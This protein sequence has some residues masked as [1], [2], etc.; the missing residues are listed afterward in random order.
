MSGRRRS[1]VFAR[2]LSRLY[3]ARLRREYEDEIESLLES[4]LERA[5]GKPWAVARIQLAAVRDLVATWVAERRA[6]REAKNGSPRKEGTMSALI[7]DVRYA[8]RRLVRTPVF[9]FGALAIMTIAIGANTAVFAAVNRMLFS[10][11]P[12]V[13]PDRV[14]NIYQDSDDGEPSSNSYPAYLDM[15][16]RSDVFASVAATSPDNAAL[17]TDG[18]R[19]AVAI[20][21]TTSSFLSVIR[22]RPLRGRWF[23]A[24][25]DQVGAGNFAVVSN[26]T[27][28]TRYGAD[29]SLIGSTIRLNGQPV[30]VIGVGPE[31]FNGFGR[32]VVTDFWL[33]ISSVGV[34]GAYRVSNLDRRQDHWYQVLA[35]LAPGVSDARAQQAMNALAASLA[36]DFPELNEGRDITVF[37]AGEVRVHPS[38]D[39]NL[40]SLGG[41]LMA[42]VVLV[43][44]LASSNLGSLLLVRGV[45]RGPEIAVRRALGAGGRRVAGLFLAEAFL[46]TFGG[47]VLGLLFA[48]WT[49]GLLATA[50]LP[51]GPLSGELDL[52]LDMPVLLFSL[53]LV[54][55]TGVFF[56]WA[57]ALQSLRTD[58]AGTLREDRRTPGGRR[59]SLLRNAMVSVQVAVSLILVALA[60]MMVRSLAASQRV[61]V[62]VDVERLAFLKTTLSQGGVPADAY[63]PVLSEIEDQFATVPGVADVAFATR[64]PVQGGGTT[65]TVVE[66]YEP[67][68]GTGSVELPWILVSPDYLATAGVR[69]LHGRGYT[70]ADQV[71][72]ERVVI[73]NETAAR[74]FWGTP[75]AVG[76]RIRP[77]SA[78]DAW[79]NVIGVVEDTKVESLN[80]PPTPLLYYVLGES[81]LNSPY[82]MVRTAGDP[83]SVLPGLR[84]ALRAVN[85]QL[86]VDGLGT[87][88]THLGS[89]LASTRASAGMLGLFS[90]LALLLASVGIYTIVSF[91]VAGRMPEIGIRVALGAARARVIRLVVGEV[92]LTVGLGLLLGTG[93]VVAVGARVGS[94]FLGMELLHAGTLATALAILVATV[95]IASY[96]P[97]RRAARVDPVHA[98]R[99]P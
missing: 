46:L 96:L 40:F 61:D 5:R 19:E 27:W 78:P 38:E 9:S 41:V 72:D 63:G 1:P 47:G 56:G 73:V 91:S 7:E 8:V 15:S 68:A 33:S 39:G 28:Q 81:G 30:T 87:M 82:I 31:D 10:P 11:L 84:T 58:L 22:R 43:L 92:A 76:R 12:Y 18:V 75:D 23:D 97:A 55:A 3:P 65:T 86:P 45:G 14:V 37:R 59:L 6:V 17:E 80:E 34:N 79:V 98:L 50:P 51:G 54:M 83:A 74:R 29:P 77:Q 49:L 90:F 69:V 67:A 64:L 24:S 35:R 44:V 26:R 36:E 99:G 93:V 32:F 20:E 70:P 88:D 85:P 94:G 52:A 42:V 48:H 21:F 95:G 25:M 4:R 13:E 57:P 62:G 16:E 71:S 66:G 89:V 53:G 60:G 2:L